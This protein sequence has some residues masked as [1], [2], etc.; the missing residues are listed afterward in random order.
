MRLVECVPNFS[1]GRNPEILEA[2]AD[3]IRSVEG[4]ELLDVDAGKAT[5][6]TVV[7]FVGEPEP[8]CEAAFQAIAK[9][10]ALIDMS[11]HTGAHPRMG[12]TDVCPF[13]PVSGVTMQDCI[14]LA[15]RLGKRVG[16]ELG[17]PV[18]LYAEAAARPERRNLADVRKGEY[19]GLAE[20]IRDPGW[21]PDFGPCQFNAAAGATV[22]GARKFLIAY[23]VNLNTRSQ[24][25]ANDIALTIREAGRAKRDAAGNIVRD[26]E[27]QPVVVPGTLK[28]AKAVGWYIQEYRRAQV[29]INLVDY[30][31]SSVHTAFDEVCRQADLLGA[32]VTGSEIVGLV[33]LA[34]MLAAGRHYLARQGRSTGVPDSELIEVAV[35]SLGLSELQP[36]DPKKKIIEYR[37][38]KEEKLL[39]NMSLADFADELSS[40]SPA[41]GGGSVA[42]LSAAL[43]ASLTSMVA[44]LTHA[45]KGFEL[46]KE[47]MDE[48]AQNAQRL[49]N[50]LLCAVDEDTQAFNQILEARR[51]PKDSEDARA[52]RDSAILDANEKATLVPLKVLSRAREALELAALAVEKG[53]PSSLS[54]AGVA[55]VL[56]RAAAEAAYYNVLTNLSGSDAEGFPRKVKE[57]ADQ[58]VESVRRA[59]DDL[60]DL[61]LSRLSGVPS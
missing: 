53:N 33:P 37:V 25:L 59:A 42:A 49:K 1:E 21:R 24:K 11:K 23:N 46:L 34:P 18:Y 19:E 61:V 8:A 38:A 14:E 20:K 5:N 29:S 12:A 27:G 3:A 17:I 35:V 52:A 7:T 30:E 39:K 28:A 41:P 51:M 26:L 2:I 55:A 43:S 13:V 36:F 47:V 10:A 58:A 9:A 32:R 45:K 48:L 56:A 40:E 4:V 57:E 60:H 31:Q 16:E 22:I 54:D 6:R 15:R 44:N 50:E